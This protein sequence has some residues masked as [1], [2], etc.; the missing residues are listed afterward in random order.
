MSD[1]FAIE[2]SEGDLA[3]LLVVTAATICGIAIGWI[4]KQLLGERKLRSELEM[5]KEHI[6]LTQKVVSTKEAQV[7]VVKAQA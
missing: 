5:I 2:D 3:S 4:A 7:K 1:K 6:G